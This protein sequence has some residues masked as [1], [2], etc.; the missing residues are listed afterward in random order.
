MVTYNGCIMELRQKQRQNILNLS[1]AITQKGGPIAPVS[2]NIKKSHNSLCF[3][4]CCDNS[5]ITI[6]TFFFSE[7]S[8]FYILG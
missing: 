8:E 7:F 3:P 1:A 2:Q 4:Q 5:L 6:F